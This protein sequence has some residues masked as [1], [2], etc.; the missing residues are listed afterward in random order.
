MSD[1]LT[2]EATGEG[3]DRLVAVLSI[4]SSWKDEK[5][6]W[7]SW[8]KTETGG[9]K[10]RRFLDGGGFTNFPAPIGPAEA[11]ETAF[12]VLSG[13]DIKKWPPKPDID[14]S[15]HRGWRVK[16]DFYGVTVE[17]FWMIYHK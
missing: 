2:V 14:G 4:C 8:R 5:P 11:A 10:F 1:S 6:E 17:P 7:L 12:S 3:K 13:I 9:I 16:Q 15:V